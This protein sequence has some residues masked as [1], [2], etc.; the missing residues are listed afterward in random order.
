MRLQS[1]ALAI[2]DGLVSDVSVGDL[3]SSTGTAVCKGSMFR[4]LR[5]CS[6]EHG[7][8]L[9]IPKIVSVGRGEWV[10]RVG[11]GGEYPD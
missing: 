9:A 8:D 10:D 2:N 6:R 7:G 5:G 3:A 1:C 4:S 11:W